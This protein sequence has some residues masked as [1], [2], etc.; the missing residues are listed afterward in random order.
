MSAFAP[1]LFGSNRVLLDVPPDH[2]FSITPSDS[3]PLTSVTRYIYVGGAGNLTLITAN[4]ETV[5]FNNVPAGTQLRIRAGFVKA[6]GTT[7]TDLV[8]LY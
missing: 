1:D 5:V 4:N 7:A 3:V 2:A 6:T 8:G